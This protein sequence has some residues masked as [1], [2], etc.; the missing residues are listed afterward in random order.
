MLR[1]VKQSSKTRLKRLQIYTGGV[2]SVFPDTTQRVPDRCALVRK[3]PTEAASQLC[4][5][6][7]TWCRGAATCRC[8]GC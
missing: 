7:V 4:A 5:W 8:L 3:K 2:R 6:C 1:R